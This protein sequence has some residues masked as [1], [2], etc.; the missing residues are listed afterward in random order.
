MNAIENKWA[1]LATHFSY[2]CH[3][4]NSWPNTSVLPESPLQH[5]FPAR[6]LTIHQDTGAV[7]LGGKPYRENETQYQHSH[8]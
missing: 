2:S 1:A 8:G 3:F 7:D 6:F 5:F 4:C